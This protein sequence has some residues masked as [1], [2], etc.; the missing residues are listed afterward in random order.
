MLLVGF[1]LRYAN[2]FPGTKREV[3]DLYLDPDVKASCC[4]K[5]PRISTFMISARQGFVG[6]HGV[7]WLIATLQHRFWLEPAPR[8]TSSPSKLF[9][10]RPFHGAQKHRI[11]MA[12][13]TFWGPP[14]GGQERSTVILLGVFYGLDLAGGLIFCFFVFFR[15]W[16]G[17]VW[18]TLATSDV[19]RERGSRL[20]LH[21]AV[22]GVVGLVL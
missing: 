13:I 6:C 20:L 18:N 1:S 19:E 3:Y 22:V 14:A 16:P 21:F 5:L 12:N 2:L 11:D 9:R 4:K 17:M 10:F 15:R 8:R 7:S